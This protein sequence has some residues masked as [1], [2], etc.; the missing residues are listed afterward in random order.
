VDKSWGEA[1]RICLT[2]GG[3]LFGP[4]R[5]EQNDAVA[6][7]ALKIVGPNWNFWIGINDLQYEGEFQFSS[8][9]INFKNWYQDQPDNTGNSDCATLFT[10]STSNYHGK[11]FDEKCNISLR[12]ICEFH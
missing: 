11:W 9:K 2:N 10:F 7:T 8:N 1:K 6:D 12:F 4:R 5:R 3:R